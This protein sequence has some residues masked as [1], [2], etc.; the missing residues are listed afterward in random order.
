ML[1]VFSNILANAIDA[2]TTGGV[3]SI[4]T[5]KISSTVGEGI[6]VV[7]RDQGAGIHQD[8][9]ENV[10]EPFFTTKGNLGIGIGL[11]VAKQ[12]VERRSG[13]IS[14]N[15]STESGKSGTVVRIFL[16]VVQAALRQSGDN[17]YTAELNLGKRCWQSVWILF[18]SPMTVAVS[19]VIQ[20]EKFKN[21]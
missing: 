2:M 10:F 8:H 20:N 16:P 12:L 6:E 3:I 15:S 7:I 18:V 14:I 9:L 17:L 1:Q 11:W 13:Q 21:R 4:H 5:R 19:L